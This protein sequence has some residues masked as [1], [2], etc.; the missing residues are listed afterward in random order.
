ME[1]HDG[2]AFEVSGRGQAVVF[3]HGICLNAATWEP[4]IALAPNDTASITLDLPGHVFSDDLAQYDY[5][6][7]ADRFHALLERLGCKNPVLVGHA[8]GAIIAKESVMSWK[9]G[10]HGSTFGG[11]P[12]CCAAAEATLDLIE[13]GLM[14][15]AARVGKVLLDGAR[16]LQRKHE[17]IG[18]VRG[19]GLMQGIECVEDRTTKAP[20]PKAVLKVFE[21][22]K[23]RGVLIGK[24]GLFGNVIRLGPPLIATQDDI[25]VLCDAL[26]AAFATV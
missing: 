3:L 22:T 9:R 4:V 26:D 20:A 16:E 19:M 14:Q 13:G 10:T 5:D 17:V 25:A 18:D 2:I 11:N 23:R 6:D 7:V 24:G 15:N 21:E 1:R 12:V 8:L